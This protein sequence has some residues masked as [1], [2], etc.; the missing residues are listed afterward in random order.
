MYGNPLSGLGL[1][2]LSQKPSIHFLS[3]EEPPH[4]SGSCPKK[5]SAWLST[6]GPPFQELLGGS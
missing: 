6:L 5:R 3:F 2:A 1:K 4:V